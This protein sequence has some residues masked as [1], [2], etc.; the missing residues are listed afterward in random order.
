M[1][2]YEIV[3]VTCISPS[4]GVGGYADGL[5][6]AITVSL[7]VAI[8]GAIGGAVG[9]EVGTAVG[10]AV[11][12]SFGGLTGPGAVAVVPAGVIA[13]AGVGAVVGGLA[14]TVG[15]IAT[16]AAGGWFV[17]T[18]LGELIDT[19]GQLIPDN[20]YIEVDGDK[21]WPS[22]SYDSISA[23]DVVKPNVR[24]SFRNSIT[25]KLKEW[26][27]GPDDNLGELILT[28]Q[29]MGVAQMYL[30]TNPDEGDV[31]QVTLSVYNETSLDTLPH[32]YADT[33]ALYKSGSNYHLFCNGRSTN[34]VYVYT[35][36]DYETL[37]NVERRTIIVDGEEI[38]TDKTTA[39]ITLNGN[40]FLFYK[41]RDSS[42]VRAVY[43]TDGGR[44]WD[45]DPAGVIPASSTDQQPAV[46]I[47]NNTLYVAFK[48]KN[49]DDVFYVTRTGNGWSS[50][51]KIDHVSTDVGPSL[52]AYDNKLYLAFKKADSHSMYYVK[53][54]AGE[55]WSDK[56]KISHDKT[57]RTPQMLAK[58]NMLYVAFKGGSTSR[59]YLKRYDGDDWAL[60]R[61]LE[62]EM[63]TD[64]Y[65]TLINSDDPSQIYMAYREEGTKYPKLAIVNGLLY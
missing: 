59:L 2:I 8:G 42:L 51:S 50:P 33:P 52:C 22:D 16:G 48:R 21:V 24:D 29:M 44:S 7:G 18:A 40:L 15:G 63:Q 57:T 64:H 39:P 47:Y 14:G 5:I 3:S 45:D 6:D 37:D 54:K 55:G 49:S 12:A 1:A 25:I 53:Y 61:K 28:E 27:V 4:T 26:D 32:D 60:H 23:G 30:L 35:S 10:A 20:L 65:P 34:K 56:H 19:L 36:A 9:T 62:S 46:A 38:R 43:S 13:G 11:G 58:G 31:Y 41:D 17:G